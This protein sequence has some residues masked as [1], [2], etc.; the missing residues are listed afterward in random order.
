MHG[1]ACFISLAASD[2]EP[3]RC[4]KE[5]RGESNSQ[6]LSAG[7][8]FRQTGVQDQLCHFLAS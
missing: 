3:Q 5:H 7:I 6:M 2:V 4:D 8:G 1:A